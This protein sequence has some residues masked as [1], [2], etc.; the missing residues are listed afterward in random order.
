MELR[1]RTLSFFELR[2][3]CLRLTDP[4]HDIRLQVASY[5]LLENSSVLC[6]GLA[7]MSQPLGRYH[8]SYYFVLHSAQ[9]LVKVRGTAHSRALE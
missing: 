9:L 4:C 7:F 2:N 5:N 6:I 3:C 1:S 8:T